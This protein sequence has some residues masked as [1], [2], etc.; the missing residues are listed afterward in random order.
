MARVKVTLRQYD[1][2]QLKVVGSVQCQVGA[3]RLTGSI[4]IVDIPS[5]YPLL[6]RDLLTEMDITLDMLL[7][8]DSVKAIAMKQ[9]GVEKEIVT[10]YND[11]FK[12]ELG[13]MRGIEVDIAV[14]QVAT[15]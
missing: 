15:P 7:K 2:T 9:T 8:Q 4:I 11:M 3:H 10:E 1:Q 13:L 6:G 14:E 12:K 5:K